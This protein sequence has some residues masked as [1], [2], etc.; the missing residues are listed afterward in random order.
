MNSGSLTGYAGRIKVYSCHS[1]DG[2]EHAFANKLATL[3]RSVVSPDCMIY[4]YKGQ[5]T[6]SH[7]EIDLERVTHRAKYKGPDNDAGT[8][9]WA[10]ITSPFY[11]GRTKNN[12]V[13]F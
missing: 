5:I 6:Q 4:G 2:G 10:I 9:R 7:E 11:V 1:A 3:L 12:R 13:L 8:H